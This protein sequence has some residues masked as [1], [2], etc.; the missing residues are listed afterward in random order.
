MSLSLLDLPVEVL[1]QIFLAAISA[2]TPLRAVRLRLVSREFHSHCG[3][4]RDVSYRFDTE[5]RDF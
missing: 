1:Q 2:R 4:Y 3:F 5:A